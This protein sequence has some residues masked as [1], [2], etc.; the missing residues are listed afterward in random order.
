[1]ENNFNIGFSLFQIV[2]EQFALFEENYSEKNKINLGTDL[3][4][5]LNKEN[6]VFIVTAKFTFEMKKKPFMTIQVSC[7]FEINDKNWIE[8]IESDKITFPKPFVS[9]MAMLTV[10][11]TRGILH[12]KTENTIFNNY[13]L[14][15]TNVAEIIA[16]DVRFDF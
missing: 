14:P 4:F 12:N 16:D 2:T 8:F 1:M 7:F 9:H 5:G 13:I 11:T 3:T 10:G 15:T 6:K